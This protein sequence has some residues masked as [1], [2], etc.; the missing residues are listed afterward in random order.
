M[1]T[2]AFSPGSGS[3]SYFYWDGQVFPNA[4]PFVDVAGLLFTG[5]GYQIN[6]FGNGPGSYSLLGAPPAY[7]PNVTDGT[8]TI[9]AAAGDHPDLAVDRRVRQYEHVQPDGDDSGRQS[10]GDGLREQQDGTVRHGVEF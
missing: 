7:A 8:A 5:G 6:L 3:D 2:Y 1:G 4:N 9:G 10:A